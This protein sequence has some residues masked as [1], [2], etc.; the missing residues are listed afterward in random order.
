MRRLKCSLGGTDSPPS[1]GVA[2]AVLPMELGCA[3]GAGKVPACCGGRAACPSLPS[4]FLP[5]LSS[6]V[7]VFKGLLKATELIRMDFKLF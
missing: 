4:R 7:V 3:M 6:R 2:P 5:H 1:P